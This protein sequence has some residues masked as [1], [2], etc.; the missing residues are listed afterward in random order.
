[1]KYILLYRFGT[2]DTHITLKANKKHNLRRKEKINTVI[3]LNRKPKKHTQQIRVEKKEKEQERERGRERH[4][5]PA[6]RTL[7]ISNFTR[8]LKKTCVRQAKPR[9]MRV[10]SEPSKG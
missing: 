10:A 8:D 4:L 1:M 6:Q 9:L 3:E 5:C 7:V 2:P